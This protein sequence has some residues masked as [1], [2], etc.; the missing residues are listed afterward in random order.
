[1]EEQETQK[2][3]G[4]QFSAWENIKS[5]LTTR[6]III[7]LVSMFVVWEIF[8]DN[9][10]LIHQ[11]KMYRENNKLQETKAD[12]KQKIIDTQKEINALDDEG[13]IE[14]VA[15]E[16]HLMKKDNEDIYIV[17]DGDKKN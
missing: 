11:Y 2:D 9:D 1:M 5:H 3:T 16:K 6:N 15:R 7:A 8:F 14:R 13:Y 4:A 12:Y 10:N 17:T